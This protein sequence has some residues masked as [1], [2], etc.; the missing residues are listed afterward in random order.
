MEVSD[1]KTVYPL[2]DKKQIEAM[3]NFLKGKN[4]RDYLMCWC[5]Y[6]FPEKGKENS[7]PLGIINSRLFFYNPFNF[8]CRCFIL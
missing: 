4:T 3:K 7:P 2:K 1:I 5:Q 8:S 6:K